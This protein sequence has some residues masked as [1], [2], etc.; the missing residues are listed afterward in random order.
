MELLRFQGE[1]AEAQARL[2]QWRA[3]PPP[4]PP[5]ALVAGLSVGLWSGLGPAAVGDRKAALRYSIVEGAI[6]G[7]AA[8]NLITGAEPGVLV[9]LGILD[10]AFRGFAAGEAARIA[11][12]RRARISGEVLGPTPP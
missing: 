9:P 5:P 4:A 11:H 10:L 6:V 2:D 7:A 8:A 12:S 1:L 3:D